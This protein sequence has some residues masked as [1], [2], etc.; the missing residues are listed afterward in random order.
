MSFH[1]VTAEKA[2]NHIRSGDFGSYNIATFGSGCH[3]LRGCEAEIVDSNTIRILDGD[4]LIDGRHARIV[5]FCDLEIRSGEVGR[6][7]ND[8][9]AIRYSKDKDGFEDGAPVVLPGTPTDGQATD[10]AFTSGS[11]EDGDVLVERPL[12][13]VPI[14]GLAVGQPVCLMKRSAPFIGHGHK[15]ADVSGAFASAL[16][17]LADV[18]PA[19]L[20]GVAPGAYTVQPTAAGSPCP[21][22]YG[23]IVVSRNGGDRTWA[24]VAFDEGGCYILRGWT[25]GG[26]AATWVRIDGG[27]K[28]LSTESGAFMHGGQTIRLSDKVS[29]QPTG[30][31][32][33][34]SY[35]NDSASKSENQH[36]VYQFVPKSH[37]EHYDGCGVTLQVATGATF[38]FIAQKYVFVSDS[39]ITGHTSNAENG[40]KNGV[41]FNNRFLALRGVLGV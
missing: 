3:I 28:V 12:Y 13:R 23:N 26:H 14:A 37:V 2:E 36:F 1:F 34:W 17:A 39:A 33:V 20:Y 21:G 35:Y 40:A 11:I 4:L 38:S 10:P 8:V 31:V 29:N 19:A 16:G 32:I 27:C 9:I 25:K 5:G 24:V 7:R 41:T 22:Q 6:N 30:I 18:T 15:A